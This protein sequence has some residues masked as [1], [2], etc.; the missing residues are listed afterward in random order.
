MFFILLTLLNKREKEQKERKNI[1]EQVK[2]RNTM[3]SEYVLQHKYPW[4][5]DWKSLKE[6][7]SEY[8]DKFNKLLI[9]EP[10]HLIE[11]EYR[12]I[13]KVTTKLKSTGKTVVRPST[14]LIGKSLSDRIK[15]FN[16]G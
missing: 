12:I 4:E 15:R 10:M 6:C 11:V 7:K 5:T 9:S 8:N 14:V 2:M 13:K 3:K 16:E 1:E